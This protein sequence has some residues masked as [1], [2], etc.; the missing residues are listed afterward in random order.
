MY[1]DLNEILDLINQ[2]EPL[3]YYFQVQD[4]YSEVID[5]MS[6]EELRQYK[7]EDSSNT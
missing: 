7:P 6:D 2:P 4:Y 3:P 5:G 1:K